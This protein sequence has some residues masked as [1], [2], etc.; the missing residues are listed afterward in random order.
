MTPI[1]L[2]ALDKS[3]SAHEF[4]RTG[5]EFLDWVADRLVLVHKESPNLDFIHCL[6]RRAEKA[7]AASLTYS[8]YKRTE[9]EL[10]TSLLKREA[11][12][13]VF[14]ML[15]TLSCGIFIGIALS[16]LTSAIY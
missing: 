4:E 12:N 8:E 9:K 11:R 15:T 7:R 1:I 2:A 16:F 6:R 10:G 13:K 5:P 14:K 3:V